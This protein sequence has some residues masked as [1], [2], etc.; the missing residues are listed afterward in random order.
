MSAKNLGTIAPT[1]TLINF[2]TSLLTKFNMA[3]VGHFGKVFFFVS[4]TY[5]VNDFGKQNSFLMSLSSLGLLFI[6][7]YVPN[8]IWRPSAILEKSSSLFLAPFSRAIPLLLLIVACRIH[9][10][11]YLY[12]W[13][14]IFMLTCLQ[15][16]YGGRRPYWKSHLL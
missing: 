15:I 5:I 9:F 3:G 10:C 14:S 12:R 1:S 8:P 11:C 2:Y 7:T 6:F 13:W 4:Y 16:Q